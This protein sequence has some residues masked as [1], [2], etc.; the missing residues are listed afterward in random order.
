MIIIYQILQNNFVN[1]NGTNKN[2]PDKII[3][4]DKAN[5]GNYILT[6]NRYSKSKLKLGNLNLDNL[7]NNKR[8]QRKKSNNKC[9]ILNNKKCNA[10]FKIIIY[11]EPENQIKDKENENTKNIKVIINRNERFHIHLPIDVSF[12][13]LIII[14]SLFLT[15]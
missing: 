13:N 8:N 11:K 3:N 4:N 15:F 9:V 14:F 2:E 1:Q 12:F 5:Y 7:L 10:C 6:R